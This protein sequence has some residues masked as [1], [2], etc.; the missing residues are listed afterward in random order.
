MISHI[1]A[2][3]KNNCIGKDGDL[4]WYIPEDMKR[5][6][7]LTKKSTVLMGRK[8]WESIPEEYRPLPERKNLVLTRQENYEVPAEV[9]VYDNIKDAIENHRDEDIMVA[10]G[11]SVYKNTMDM[12]DKLF[13]THVEQEVEKCDAFYPKIRGDKW[14]E[15]ERESH[16]G[17]TFVT[18]KRL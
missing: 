11:E 4:P 6:K 7:G 12:A 3:S 14:Q 18:Y 13:I 2:I 17:F 8:T 9:K 16:D 15:I 10:G 1:A 5:F